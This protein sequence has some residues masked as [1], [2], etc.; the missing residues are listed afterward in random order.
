MAEKSD[1]ITPRHLHNGYAYMARITQG[2]LR[3]SADIRSQ[4]TGS[5]LLCVSYHRCSA[6]QV[7]T[8]SLGRA[9]PEPTQ[10]GR[11]TAPSRDEPAINCPQSVDP[12]LRRGVGPSQYHPHQEGFCHDAA[13]LPAAGAWLV[14]E[15]GRSRTRECS[16]ARVSPPLRYSVVFIILQKFY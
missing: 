14:D 13:G 16:S 4:S 5:A 6:L 1:L 3:I 12:L 7:V 10:V 8:Q 2:L 11:G 9:P 15:K